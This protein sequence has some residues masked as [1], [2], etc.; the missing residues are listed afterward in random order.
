[1]ILL[2]EPERTPG[3]MADIRSRV[4]RPLARPGS[5]T[6]QADPRWPQIIAELAALRARWRHAIRIVDAD[7][8]CGTLLIAAAR[9]ARALGFTAIEARGIDGSPALIGRAR[10]AAARLRDPA[11]GLFFDLA[12]MRAA[13]AAEAAFPADLVLWHGKRGEPSD[14]ALAAALARAGAKVIIDPATSGSPEQ[15]A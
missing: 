4:A 3:R 1:M 12:D 2:S 6:A 15:A 5:R 10:G 9:Q 8:A 7:C 14:A 13:L 11:I